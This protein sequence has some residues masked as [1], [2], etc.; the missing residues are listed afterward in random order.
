MIIP[1]LHCIHHS[2]IARMAQHL[3]ESFYNLFDNV[4][5]YSSTTAIRTPGN[6]DT[7]EIGSSIF[8]DTA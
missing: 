5:R 1:S 7:T 8:R 3:M 6:R 4:F 2:V